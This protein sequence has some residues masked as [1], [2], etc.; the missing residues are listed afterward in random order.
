MKRETNSPRTG[1]HPQ[2]RGTT[3]LYLVRHEEHG[4]TTVNG[5]NK[6]D[7]VTAAARIW[8]VP[9]TSIARACELVILA[10]DKEL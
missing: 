2:A 8:G 6:Y 7:A 4:E 3:K 1:Y 9:W 5:V 10:E